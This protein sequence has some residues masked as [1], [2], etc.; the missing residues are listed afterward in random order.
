MFKVYIKVNLMNRFTK[1]STFLPKISISLMKNLNNL[2]QLCIN[3]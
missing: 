3:Y 1:F 2:L